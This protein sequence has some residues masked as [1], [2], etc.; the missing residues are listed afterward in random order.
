[1]LAGENRERNGN[2]CCEESL[3]QREVEKKWDGN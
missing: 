1:M 3:L 2:G